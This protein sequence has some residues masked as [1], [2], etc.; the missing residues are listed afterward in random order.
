MV[1]VRL[2]GA[3][4]TNV[5]AAV[6]QILSTFFGLPEISEIDVEG[7][8][9]ELDAGGGFIINMYSVVS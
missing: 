3:R 9:L 1:I 8:C 6:V 7:V 2:T 4:V 5:V